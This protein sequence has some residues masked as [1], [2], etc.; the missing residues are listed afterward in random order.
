MSGLEKPL[1]LEVAPGDRETLYVAE[2]TGRIRTV[3]DDTVTG[4]FLDVRD[5]LAESA[6]ETGLLGFAFHPDYTENGRLFVRYSAPPPA[7]SDLHH[8]ELLSE[9]AVDDAGVD[10]ESE[11]VLLRVPQPRYYHNA[12]SVARLVDPSG[13]DPDR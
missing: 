9:F 6:S 5:R 13:T 7:D 12:G 2:Q 1:G 8:V 4:T 3:R 10:H 11:R